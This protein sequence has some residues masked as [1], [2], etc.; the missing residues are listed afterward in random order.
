MS[1]RRRLVVVGGVAAGMSAASRARRLDPALEILVFE[2]T[3]YVSYGS[4]GLPYYIG[5]LVGTPEELVTYSPR[6]FKEKR[7][8]D[9]FVRHEVTGIDHEARRVTVRRLSDGETLEFGYDVLV[10]ATGASAVR[11]PVPGVGRPGVFVLRVLE[12]GIALRR[13]IER[14]TGP[15]ALPGG[16]AP[17]A[18][19]VGAGPIGVEVAESFVGLGFQVAMVEMMPQVLPG[20]HPELAALLEAQLERHGIAV[21]T[22][23]KVAAIEGPGEEGP[24]EAVV[25]ASGRTLPADVVVLG[26]GVRPNVELARQA[27]IRLG[28][29]GA[30][31]VDERLRTSV[32]DVFAAGD[33]VETWH[34]V[35]RRPV[36][37]P[38]GTTANKMGRI[39]GENAAGG[40]AVFR[41]VVGTAALR[42]FD[43]EVG[44]TG[45][46][47]AEA[48]EA[49]FEPV[50]AYVRHGSRAHY[51]P[52]PGP[53]HVWLVGDRRTG[54]VL[55]AQLLGP[56]GA[57]A[58]RVD[59]L[60]VAVTAGLGVDEVAE[61]DLS[62]AP[63][64]APVWDPVLMAARQWL[65]EAG[66]DGA[67]EGRPEGPERPGG[68]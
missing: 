5:G 34:R 46:A 16:R 59:V 58:K 20:Y 13:H 2:R 28:A 64:F 37:I 33:G 18:V 22:G 51:Y 68:R 7:D 65:K 15:G 45:L 26:T 49:G 14:L 47:E 63:A 57:V 54:R 10:L 24:V 19:L 61:L 48:A 41:G 42:A 38:L 9:V 43:L 23:E 4:C 44:R 36:W 50:T 3:G 30:V 39:A 27:G 25:T 55:G 21:H 62:Y 32:P 35:L 17:R 6:F 11:P 40:H 56:A 12:D 8:I 60:A 1:A 29:T 52:G 53:V 31:A 67:G 66:M